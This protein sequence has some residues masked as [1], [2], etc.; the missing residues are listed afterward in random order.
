MGAFYVTSRRTQDNEHLKK[1]FNTEY[2]YFSA[3]DQ[4][5]APTPSYVGRTLGQ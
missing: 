5:Y 3:G 1:G 4:S 2:Q